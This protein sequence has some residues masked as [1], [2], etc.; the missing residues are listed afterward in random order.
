MATNN[1]FIVII[2]VAIVLLAAFGV[3]MFFLIKKLSKSNNG[4][5]NGGDNGGD[6]S[7][8]V[9]A[10]KTWNNGAATC[11]DFCT[12]NGGDWGTKYGGA[13]TATVTGP[14]GFASRLNRNLAT[15]DSI[16]VDEAPGAFYPNGD[17]NQPAYF[18]LDCGCTN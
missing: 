2:V 9:V 3:G 12:N 17:V 1:K 13:A 7:K 11:R 6:K 10:H 4:G 8:S 5:N 15:G 18:S 16:S 14:G